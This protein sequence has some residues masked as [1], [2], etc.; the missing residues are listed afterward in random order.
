MG[1]VM[2]LTSANLLMASLQLNDQARKKLWEYSRVEQHILLRLYLFNGLMVVKNIALKPV[3][4][5]FNVSRND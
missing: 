2:M 4:I 1:N 3:Y 5:R